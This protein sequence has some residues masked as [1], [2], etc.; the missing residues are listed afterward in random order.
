ML[1]VLNSLFSPLLEC[2]GNY[3]A[4]SNDVMLVHWPLMDGL[5]RLVQR[6]GD[7]SGLQ[8]AQLPRCTKCSSPPIYGQ[9]TNHR[10]AV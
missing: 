9:C 1:I 10:I 6:G 7:W 3:S 4:A 8:P 2:R 5:L